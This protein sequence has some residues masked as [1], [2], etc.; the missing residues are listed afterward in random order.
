MRG[1][2][3]RALRRAAKTATGVY[4]KSIDE[5]DLE[6]LSGKGDKD[7]IR[8]RGGVLILPYPPGTSVFAYKTIKKLH[9]R[10]KP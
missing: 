3:A 9:R 2:V 7:R 10:G 5:T 4:P 8:Q 1:K 6:A